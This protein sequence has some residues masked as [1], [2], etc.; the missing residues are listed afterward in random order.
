MTGVTVEV[1]IVNAFVDGAEGGNPAGVVLEAEHLSQQEKQTTAAK[2]GFS[3][4]AFVSSS[5]IADF[6]LEFFTPVCR[7]ADCGHATVAAFSYLAQ[8]GKI[9]GNRTSKEIISGRRDI[10]ISGDTVSMEQIP[11]RYIPLT[12]ENKTGG[13]D[14]TAVLSSLGLQPR[15]L[16]KG[17][18]PVIA[19]NGFNC[20]IVP[21]KD[22][23]ALLR[24]RPGFKAIEEIGKALDLVEYYVFS[25]DT[26]R[27]G[28][29]AGARMFA[30]MIGIPEEAATGMAA[31]PLACFLYDYLNI[32]KNSFIIEQGH[33]MN[34]PSPSVLNAQLFLEQ[35]RVTGLL[36]GGRAEVTNTIKVKLT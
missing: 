21:L 27:P 19:N 2:V 11:P 25:P 17:Q 28:R 35:D 24:I 18:E 22:E 10:F 14:S 32:K 30:P 5:K 13:P 1:K 12:R 31:G 16:L 36:V 33:L 34:P 23:A 7:I 8:L 20:L 26:R 15:D 29:D 6:K 4:T 9:P 3:E